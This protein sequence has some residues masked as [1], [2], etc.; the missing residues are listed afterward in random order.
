MQKPVGQT[1]NKGELISNGGA[2]HHWPPQ[3]QRP[4]EEGD[5]DVKFLQ[6]SRKIKN[7][8]I[9]PEKQDIASVPEM[10]WFGDSQDPSQLLKQSALV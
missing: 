9:F 1:W 10:I 4:C 6:T 3:W 2:G 8:F 5:W 7:G